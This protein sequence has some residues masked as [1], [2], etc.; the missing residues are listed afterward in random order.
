MASDPIALPSLQY[1]REKCADTID[2][3]GIYTQPDRPTGRGKKLTPNAI[4]TWALEHN[5]PCYQP[6]KMDADA[7]TEF[8]ALKADVVLVMAYGHI[9]PKSMLS[10]PRLGFYNL[11]ASLLPKLRGAS[12][13]ETAIVTGETETGVTLME[14]VPALDAGPIVEKI[15]RPIPSEQTSQQLREVLGL[16]CVPLLEKTLPAIVNESA[17]STPQSPED[18]TYCRLID[19]SDGYLDFSLS[20]SETLN[21]IR[22]FQPW[23]GALFVIDGITFRI[24]SASSVQPPIEAHA[25]HQPGLLIS[26]KKQLLLAVGDGWI[27][28]LE[29]QKPGGKMLPTPQFLNGHKFENETMIDYPERFPLVKD[30]YFRKSTSSGE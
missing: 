11:H 15:H 4:K 16:A 6:L 18:A 8:E 30:K 23:P 29:I 3:I 19:K 2:L 27:E 20:V 1:I 28:V 22:G 5:L 7:I 12:P 25:T 9:L 21:H 17:S 24:G 26:N 10:I 13:I 14:V